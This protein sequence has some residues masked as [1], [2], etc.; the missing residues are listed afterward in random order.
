MMSC[1]A[2]CEYVNHPKYLKCHIKDENNPEI[3]R[4]R[5]EDI[6]EK[7]FIIS[8]NEIV[9]IRY[10]LI[11]GKDSRNCKASISENSIWRWIVN[12][13][14]MVLMCFYG[15]FLITLGIFNSRTGAYYRQLMTK[16]AWALFKLFTV[17]G[18][19]SEF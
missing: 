14:T 16:K 8:N 1:I 9:R 18:N 19:E 2:L 6:P 17:K 13:K 15:L 4:I 12:N 7:Y 3:K 5:N 10:L 11:Y